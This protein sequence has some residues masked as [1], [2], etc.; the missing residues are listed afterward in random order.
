M[1]KFANVI[2]VAIQI[3]LVLISFQLGTKLGAVL[4]KNLAVRCKVRIFSV[5]FA[6]PVPIELEWSSYLDSV[7]GFKAVES[8]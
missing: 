2:R 5:L 8:R 7:P 4:L 3:L 6:L 1:W